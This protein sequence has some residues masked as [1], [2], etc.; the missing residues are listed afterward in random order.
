MKNNDYRRYI[1][2]FINHIHNNEVL[3]KIYEIVQ[4]FYNKQK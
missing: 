4:N 1:V 2:Y 3:K